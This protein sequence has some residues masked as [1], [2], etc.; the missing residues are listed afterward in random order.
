MEN[1]G[2]TIEKI[3]IAR[4]EIV[5]ALGNSLQ[6]T[7]ERLIGGFCGIGTIHRF[8]ADKYSNPIGA[9]IRD[10]AP[11]PDRSMICS[12]L[13]KLLLKLGPLSPETA[14][15]TATTKLG[16]DNLEKHR[17][18]EIT[19]IEDALPVS[20]PGFVSHKLNLK[21]EGVN[22]SAS[23]ASSTIAIAQ[24]SAM[25]SSGMADTVLICC[26][27]IITE[28]TFSGFSALKIL[29]PFPSKPFDRNRDGITLGDGAAAL[30]L[31]SE[32]YAR[33]K[34]YPCL[35]V[36]KGWGS[37]S[38]AFHII[39]PATDGSGLLAAVYQAFHR[40]GITHKHVSGISAHGTGTIYNDNMELAVIGR[41]FGERKV[42]VY[43]IKGTIGH[44]LGASG[45]IEVALAVK[46]L[47][48][49][50]IPPT[51]GLQKPEREAEGYVS[52][53]PVTF[54]GD[55]LLTCNSG[56]GGINAAI[57]LEKGTMQ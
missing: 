28:F 24:A 45:G 12:L 14:L 42:P 1:R 47:E 34:G 40:A 50:I 44:T 41:I 16:I 4:A 57:V 17:K 53:Q 48:H 52:T 37:A 38:D 2:T 36:V 8:A 35:A 13:E 51:V 55:Y 20:M 25:I 7:W 32:K 27:D 15:I 31:M 39:S 22:V 19:R 3:W 5:T 46:A 21:Q 26:A 9:C 29:S 11:S 6:E 54:T 23:C 43:S 33:E 30:L 10:L 56:F 18:K 49:R